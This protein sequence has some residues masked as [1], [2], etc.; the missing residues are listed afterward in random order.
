MDRC[1][2]EMV[3]L[4]TKLVFVLD[5]VL[6]LEIIAYLD[7]SYVYA[8]FVLLMNEGTRVTID[9]LGM[10]WPKITYFRTFLFVRVKFWFPFSLVETS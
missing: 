10:V 2:R 5:G 9:C 8:F 3:V 6:G 1:L 7:S 4:G